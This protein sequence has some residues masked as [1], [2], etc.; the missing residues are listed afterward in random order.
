[1]KNI[2]LTKLLIVFSFLFYMQMSAIAEQKVQNLDYTDALQPLNNPG[3]GF[4]RTCMQHVSV[5]G[6]KAID[7][8]GNLVHLRV[9]ISPF[10]SN[11]VLSVDETT[12]DTVFGESKSLT[13]DALNGIEASLDGIRQRGKTAVVRV[14]YD[15]WYNG[16]SQPEPSEQSMVL[17]HIKQLAEV[18]SR[19]TDVIT[20]VELGMYGPWGEMHTSRIGTNANI[21]EALQTMLENTPSCLKIGVRRPDI[22]AEWMGLEKA[23]FKVDSEAFKAAAAEKGD[24]MYRVGLYNDGYLGSSSD[25][26]TIDGT[27]NREMMVSWLEKYSQNTPYG[28]ELVANYNG[29][30]PINTPIYLSQEGFRTH[31]T[32][33][34]YEWH[35]PTILAWKDTVF[36]GNDAE[37]KGTDGFTYVENHLGYRLVLRNSVLPD[38]VVDCH[39]Q[40]DLKIQNVGFGNICSEKEL[41]VILT[42]GKV[43]AELEP[44]TA[45]DVRDLRSRAMGSDDS[46]D[47][48]NNVALE[49]ELPDSL[50]E[51]SYDV[52]LRISQHGD[53]LTDKNY[54]CIQFANPD[55]QYNVNFGANLVGNFLLEKPKTS[56]EEA[57]S[58]LSSKWWQAGEYIYTQ[59]LQS[60]DIFDLNG[61]LLKHSDVSNCV[62]VYV[63]KS[64]VVV[65]GK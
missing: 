40:M 7:T 17:E 29:D 46:F 51:G 37:Y 24:T 49:V 30:H 26:G 63:G 44:L 54:Q 59:G 56:I 8:W 35:Q 31:T 65:V 15:P 60:I 47:G 4:Y 16:T 43:V 50:Q 48:T 58:E 21:A 23:D 57:S 41:T 62:P 12:N 52:Y 36:T 28:G 53:W 42:N 2:F 55:E 11:A 27:L 32:Y 18:Y 22:V 13:K 64:R 38:N 19:N 14:C 9:D 33:L 10:S 34:N 6:N 39:L 1:M 5:L 61:R 25:L 45:F 20:Y 3:R